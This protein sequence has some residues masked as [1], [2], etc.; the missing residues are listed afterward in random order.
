MKTRESFECRVMFDQFTKSN[1][2][3][4]FLSFLLLF[5][6]LVADYTVPFYTNLRSKR[7][8][9]DD[10]SITFGRMFIEYLLITVA[11]SVPAGRLV[12]I[13]WT[14]CTRCDLRC[15]CSRITETFNNPCRRK[16]MKNASL[17]VRQIHT[18]LSRNR[19]HAPTIV[20][21]Q[22]TRRE[23]ILVYVDPILYKNCLPYE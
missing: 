14:I 18:P 16:T 2:F 15:A 19:Q 4:E 22:A 11:I 17:C 6:P 7:L 3:P 5:S 12:K 10:T 13:W 20:A 23:S 1:P 8:L 9:P 21:K